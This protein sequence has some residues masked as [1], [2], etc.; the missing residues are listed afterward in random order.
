MPVTGSSSSNS[1]EVLEFTGLRR[2]AG[3]LQHL[4][5]ASDLVRRKSP[6]AEQRPAQTPAA[7]QMQAEQHVLQAGQ[8]LKQRGELKRAH[9]PA[10]DDLMRPE[11]ADVFAVEP[12]GAG[13]GSDEAGQQVEAGR[14][15][16][17]IRT[18]QADDLALRNAEIDTVD[19]GESAEVPGET[20][21]LEKKRGA[22][23][24]GLGL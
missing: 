14:L 11:S 19:G 12:D 18:D 2:Q 20:V 9:Q 16:R 8:L 24:A 15:A 7:V 3:E 23:A 21:C 5:A 13:G 6:T 1:R 17:A 22:H 4:A 10:L